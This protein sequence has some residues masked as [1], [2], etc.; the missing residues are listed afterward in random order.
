[1][2]LPAITVLDVEVL[3]RQLDGSAHQV[4][5]IFNERGIV[6]GDV[7]RQHA[8]LG[9]EGIAHRQGG[10][11]A[12]AAM[13]YNRKVEVRGDPRWVPERA[14]RLMDALGP[15]ILDALRAV[16]PPERVGDRVRC[17]RDYQLVYK[18]QALGLLLPPEEKT[19]P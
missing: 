8:E 10:G 5:C 18:G 12:L 15:A 16:P 19:P 1:M 3:A 2:T 4:K 17:L 13:V 6:F 7:R 14:R 9:A 11:N